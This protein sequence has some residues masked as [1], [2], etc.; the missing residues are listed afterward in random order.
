MPPADTNPTPSPISSS[1]SGLALD[2]TATTTTESSSTPSTSNAD[3]TTGSMSGVES[4]SGTTSSSSSG[5]GST[6]TT[7]TGSG[8]ESSTGAPP[9]L[10]NDGLVAPGEICFDAAAQIVT[11]EAVYSAQL[12]PLGGTPDLD[13]VYLDSD[14]LII[15]EG[16][17][18]G[19]FGPPM[20]ALIV[21]GQGLALGLF[22]A[23]ANLDLAVLGIMGQPTVGV[24]AGDGA[25][26]F[27]L[28]D[29]AMMGITA[30]A[31]DTIDL[32]GDGS[33]DLVIG[34][35][36][37]QALASVLGDGLGAFASG[38][39]IDAMRPVRSLALGPFGGA[40]NPG[41]A[42]TLSNP[43]A[44][45]EY[46]LGDGLGSFAGPIT[47]PAIANT[48][49]DIVVADF[50]DDGI[51]DLAYVTAP[52]DDLSVLLGN[53][54]GA[55][56]PEVDYNADDQPRALVA[57]DM[58]SDGLLDLVVGHGGGLSTA[59]YIYAGDGIGGFAPPQML[60]QPGAVSDLAV[61]DANGDAVPDI[62]VTSEIGQIVTVLL[63]TP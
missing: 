44:P 16:D 59:I 43:G 19:G 20:S 51:N 17:G 31:I 33:V 12:A 5:S 54:L 6:G 48:G 10:C 26:G 15:H 18:M 24:Y 2:T 4:S 42:Y 36:M 53:N 60:F 29:S 11:A 22:D 47:P 27:A 37:D 14:E 50:D 30:N 49:E 8:S 13:L 28:V 56:L 3:P 39:I 1:S 40:G 35:E 38:P 41:V 63:S 45:V 9:I 58:N 55:F 57:A 46:R 25:F 32:E 61:G 62:V 7:S 23:D 52:F 21:M 34:S